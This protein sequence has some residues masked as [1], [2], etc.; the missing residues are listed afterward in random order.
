M[1][2]KF[3]EDNNSRAAAGSSKFRAAVLLAPKT[4]AN[5]DSCCTLDD[6]ISLASLNTR[7]AEANK[8]AAPLDTNTNRFNFALM[9]RFLNKRM[10]V[11]RQSPKSP[12]GVPIILAK[13]NNL[14]LNFNCCR[15]ATSMLTSKRTLLPSIK[16]SIV[17]PCSAKP[18]LSP[19]SKTGNF[20]DF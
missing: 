17:P 3:N 5:A 6:P 4:L 9:E 8:S 1:G 15:L 11:C 10:K 12:H 13:L 14:E 18:G 20:C 2:C 16:K 19:T 7:T